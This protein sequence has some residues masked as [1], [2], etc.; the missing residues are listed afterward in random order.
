MKATDGLLNDDVSV[1]EFTISRMTQ[2]D[3][4]VVDSL[5]H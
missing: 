1:Q 2:T 3:L 4:D 5:A